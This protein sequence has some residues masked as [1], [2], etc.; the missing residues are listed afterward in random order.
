MD[1]I[2]KF[3]LDLELNKIDSDIF[4][5]LGVKY[6]HNLDEDIKHAAVKSR[7]KQ[8]KYYKRIAIVALIIYVIGLILSSFDFFN[9]EFSSD[10]KKILKWLGFSCSV[11]GIMINSSLF[12]MINKQLKRVYIEN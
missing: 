2:K 4:E 12:F 7:I 5:N 8:T 1:S 9:I 3:D 6:K 11:I 10:A